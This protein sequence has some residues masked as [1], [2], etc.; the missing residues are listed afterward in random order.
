MELDL[1]TSRSNINSAEVPFV[2]V[3]PLY[4]MIIVGLPIPVSFCYWVSK[5]VLQIY[6]RHNNTTAICSFV[7]GKNI[8]QNSQMLSRHTV[9]ARD[10][11]TFHD[12]NINI[13]LKQI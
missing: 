1:Y 12:K 7:V 9:A 6:L 3:A 10:Y 11:H 13:F 5:P 4:L 8:L 2:D